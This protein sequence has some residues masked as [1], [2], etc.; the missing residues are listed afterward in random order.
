MLSSLSLNYKTKEKGEVKKKRKG[1]KRCVFGWQGLGTGMTGKKN[2]LTSPNCSDV[3]T[4]M[5]FWICFQESSVIVGI[6]IFFQ[7]SI[8]ALARQWLELKIWSSVEEFRKKPN[9]WKK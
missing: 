2:H 6:A 9:L 5:Q 7:E 1:P 8:L 3:I 4:F